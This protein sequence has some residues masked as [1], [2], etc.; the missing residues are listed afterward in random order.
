[1]AD[2][3]LDIA[4]ETHAEQTLTQLALRARDIHAGLGYTYRRGAG[5]SFPLQVALYVHRRRGKDMTEITEAEAAR[6]R[7]L[8]RADS[9][10]L[11][12]RNWRDPRC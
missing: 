9:N 3:L 10:V 6:N 8:R 12:Q 5:T 11:S 2:R 7:Q 4:H 1:M